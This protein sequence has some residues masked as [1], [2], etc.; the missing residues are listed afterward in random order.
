MKKKK[1]KVQVIKRRFQKPHKVNNI[2]NFKKDKKAKKVLLKKEIIEEKGITAQQQNIK[3]E[4]KKIRVKII[5]VGGGGSAIVSE[6][7]SQIKRPDFLVADTDIRVLK[8]INKKVKRFHFGQSFTRGFGTGMSVEIGELA[9]EK[10][11]DKIKKI[12]EGIDLVIIV[13]CLGGGTGSGAV[14]VFAKIVKNCGIPVYGIF[15]FPFSFEGERKMEIARKS[16]EK[17]KPYLNAFS[18]IPNENIFKIIDKNTPLK[19]AFSIVNQQLIQ[20]LEGLI[21]MIYLPGLINIDFADLKAILLGQGKLAFLSTI[22]ISPDKIDQEEGLKNLISSPLYP[23]TLKGGREVLYNIVGGKELQLNEVSKIS[24]I[25]LESVNKEAKI[26]FG[27]SQNKEYK[28]KIKITILVIGC[29]SRNDLFCCGLPKLKEKEEKP[30]KEERIKKEKKVKSKK[31]LAK[32]KKS[33]TLNSKN[34]N[35]KSNLK[36]KN[37]PVF[38]L[39][40]TNQKK[41]EVYKESKEEKKDELLPPEEKIRRNAIEVKKAIEDEEKEILEKEKLLETPTILRKINNHNNIL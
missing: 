4:I 30:L 2:L 36:V 11:K 1:T 7:A 9:A 25:I 3:E 28:E 13:S 20:N 8:E 37:V 38:K 12:F 23:Y 29:A 22:E 17:T 39:S 27:I 19:K 33:K 32:I 31:V 26:I 5:G 16:L 14:P 34:K 35:D 18:V 6:I 41:E 10:E 15:T 40:S 21:E 24:R